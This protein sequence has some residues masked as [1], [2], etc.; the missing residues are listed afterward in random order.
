MSKKNRTSFIHKLNGNKRE[1]F[2]IIEK[3]DKSLVIVIKNEDNLGIPIKLREI[4][5]YRISLRKLITSRISIHN[6]EKTAISPCFL[7]NLS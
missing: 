1:L 5:K 2:F 4:S 7:Q 6:S 3:P